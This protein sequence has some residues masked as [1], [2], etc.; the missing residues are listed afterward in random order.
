[1]PKKKSA[2]KKPS[3]S[4]ELSLA[5]QMALWLTDVPENIMKHT[6]ELLWSIVTFLENMMAVYSEEK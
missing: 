3:Q 2:S 6:D 4:C 5:N 1:M